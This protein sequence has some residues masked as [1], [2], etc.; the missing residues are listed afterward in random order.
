MR[1]NALFGVLKRMQGLIANFKFLTSNSLLQHVRI[2]IVVTC[3]EAGLS[4]QIHQE[5]VT[6]QTE[7]LR[8]NSNSPRH[9]LVSPFHARH[10]HTPLFHCLFRHRHL[11][12]KVEPWRTLGGG[13]YLIQQR[14]KCSQICASMTFDCGI[15]ESSGGT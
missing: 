10:T 9:C 4:G 15:L 2:R 5:S 11:W 7:P 8:P 13:M 14:R 6:H 12:S 1:W 3:L